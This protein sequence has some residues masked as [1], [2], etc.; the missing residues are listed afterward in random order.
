MYRAIVYKTLLGGCGCR[1]RNIQ[2]LHPPPNPPGPPP[3]MQP[4]SQPLLLKGRR[5]P[6]SD[7]DC[8]RNRGRRRRRR[9][10]PLLK[11]DISRRAAE[12][13]RRGL[14]A[15]APASASPEVVGRK[16]LSGIPRKRRS[17]FGRDECTARTVRPHLRLSQSAVATTVYIRDGASDSA[18]SCHYV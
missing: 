12:R 11:L 9:P 1:E 7:L 17:D 16:V 10:R 14:R 5:F 2:S 15:L 3:K 6:L 13:E 8:I 4:L 18:H